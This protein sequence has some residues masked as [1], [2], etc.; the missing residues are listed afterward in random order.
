MGRHILETPLSSSGDSEVEYQPKENGNNGN[1]SGKYVE[2]NLSDWPEPELIEVELFSVEPFPFQILPEALEP[3]VKDVS[4][5]MQCPPDFIVT[6]AMTL[7][8]SIIGTRCGIRPKQ[9]DDWFVL[10]NLWGGVVGR[11]SML[12]TP[13]LNE[14]L[15]PLVRLEAEAKETFDEENKG[16]EVNLAEHQAI[17]KNLKRKME[18]A[19][20]GKG[21]EPMEDIKAELANLPEPDEPTMHRYKTNDATIEK[22][23]ELLNENPCGLL[24]FRDELVG[25]LASWEKP[26]RE[27]DRAFFLE[28]WDGTGSHTS[29]RIGRGTIFT[30]NLCLSVFGGIQPSKLTS[31]LYQSMHGLENDGLIQRLQMLVY[32]D[33]IGN[34]KLIDQVP[35]KE[36]RDRAFHLIQRLAEMDFTEFGATQNDNERFPYLHFSDEA[37]QVFNG[38]LTDL[39]LKKLRAEDHPMILEHLGK[40]RSLMPSIA[41][42]IHLIG[43]AD[44]AASGPITVE[45]AER[46]SAWCEY[47]ES[48][49]R[50]VYGLVMDVNQQAGTILAE[51]I[52]QGKLTDGFTVRDVYRQ[53]WHLLNNKEL[54]QAAC[55]EL[56]EAGWLKP[57]TTPAR[58]GQKGKTE[59]RINPKIL[60]D[61]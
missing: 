46:A 7:I 23:S 47:L 32:P 41:L 56:V 42:I 30:D 19:A 3:W 12:K 10:P 20:V 59:Y 4:H 45:S 15:R 24:L 61:S 1:G 57:E 2:D 37:Q 5:R 38:W 25:L 53:N 43:V 26:G 22:L 55:D 52:M 13:A 48:H 11:P 27:S 50:R 60:K 35:E 16:H 9:H 33:E 29:D 34:W 18:K 39:E 21:G 40:Y 58:F 28:S 6:A 36:A 54:A 14:A 8:G 31:Y 44:G 51:K 17:K 49:M